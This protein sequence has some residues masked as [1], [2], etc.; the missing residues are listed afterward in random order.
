MIDPR[1][2]EIEELIMSSKQLI[3]ECALEI[4]ELPEGY[5]GVC[6]E[7]K[8]RISSETLIHY[9]SEK[10]GKRTRIEVDS[11][12]AKQLARKKY[13]KQ[14]MKMLK[15]NMDILKGISG[16]YITPSKQEILN[17]MSRVYSKLPAEIYDNNI[18]KEVQIW[19][20]QPYERDLR[21][22]EYNTIPTFTGTK[23]KSKSERDIFE[24]LHRNGR[25][26][27]YEQILHIRG[28]E[29]AP[30]FTVPIEYVGDTETSIDIID[31]MKVV[32]WE[33]LGLMSN[34]RY[35]KTFRWKLDEYES[36]GIYPGKNLIITFEGDGH[37]LSSSEIEEIIKSKIL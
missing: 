19:A 31:G 21:Y 16:D 33:H 26:P 29:L 34:P 36:V 20:S 1:T 28:Y 27:R 37:F 7:E 14:E 10:G 22:E 4:E 3:E 24:M 17:T 11:I 18:K 35:R 32:F 8:G 9:H 13:L 15:K 25:P 2:F 12:I 5:L 23:V 30:D 6:F